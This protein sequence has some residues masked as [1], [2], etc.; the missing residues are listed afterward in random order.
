MSAAGVQG[1]SVHWEHK[2]KETFRF[3][4]VIAL[5]VFADQ[6]SKLWIVSHFSLY[7]SVHVIPGFFNLTY[8]TN[9]GAAFG[10]L[11]GHPAVWRHT[12]FICVA[13]VALGV[14]FVLFFRLRRESYWYELSLAMIAGGAMGNLVDR[15]RHG[16]VTD[17][18]DFYVGGYHWPA[19]NVADSAI[20]V[21][22]TIFLVYNLF[23]EA[24]GKAE[25]SSS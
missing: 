18:L 2:M 7:E 11:A 24:K 25:I 5:V 10:F 23:F 6:A 8:L 22:V 3:G 14:I 13:L 19:F 9:T 21:G 1:S 12:F 15:I 16:A 4:A 20:T 17:F